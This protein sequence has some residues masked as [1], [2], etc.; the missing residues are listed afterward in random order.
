[1][2]AYSTFEA[3]A[4]QPWNPFI[5][6][7]RP[8]AAAAAQKMLGKVAGATVRNRAT[9]LFRLYSA[10]AKDYADT[11]S[12]QMRGWHDDQLQTHAWQPVALAAAGAELSEL[13]ARSGRRRAGCAARIRLRDDDRIFA[14]R[15]MAGAA[16]ACI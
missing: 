3:Q 5:G 6:Y 1:M 4:S 14:A 10:G 15:R 7:G 8:D 13:S 16:A 9:P 12:P 2:L 11:T